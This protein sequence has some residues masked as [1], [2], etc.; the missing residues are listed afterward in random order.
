MDITDKKVICERLQTF[1]SYKYFMRR[2]RNS[3]QSSLELFLD[4]ICNTFGGILFIAI[5]IAIQ[6]RK[7]EQ[8][9]EVQESVSAEIIETLQQELNQRSAEIESATILLETLLNS[10]PEPKTNEE[11]D[12]VN[13]YNQLSAAKGKA[14]TKKGELINQFLALGQENIKLEN[15]IKDIETKLQ[16]LEVEEQSLAQSIQQR[17]NKNHTIKLSSDHLQSEME[18]LDRQMARKEKTIKDKNDPDANTRSEVLYLPKLHDAGNKRPLGLMLCY[19]RLYFIG[20]RDD[21][22]FIGNEVG[23]PK[24]NRGIPI[25]DSEDTKRK[26]RSLLKQSSS[27]MFYINLIVY[28]NSADPFHIVRD[29]IISDGFK[30]HLQPAEDGTMFYFGRGGPAQVQ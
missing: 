13:L 6:I 28:A 5:L 18:E 20:D 4:T 25:S 3:P 11:K 14:V 8:K 21:F 9:T 22:N 17:K 15:Q 30:Y 2:R 27:S 10:M 7:T 1:Y 29:C 19:N 23:I 12:C 24:K 26:I 16:Q